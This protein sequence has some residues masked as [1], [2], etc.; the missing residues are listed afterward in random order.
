MNKVVEKFH[1]TIPSDILSK[2]WNW[3]LKWIVTK[4]IMSLFMTSNMNIRRKQWGGWYLRCEATGSSSEAPE[5]PGV[6]QP[7]D[8]QS[9]WSNKAVLQGCRSRKWQQ[10]QCGCEIMAPTA[11]TRVQPQG[12]TRP[13]AVVGQSQH[14]ARRVC[15]GLELYSWDIYLSFDV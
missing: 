7:S 12:Y 5:S 8:Y 3:F 13:H 1:W 14:K 2:T 15:R 6:S 9:V 10:T 4:V 11:A